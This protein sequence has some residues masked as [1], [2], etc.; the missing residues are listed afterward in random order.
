[1]KTPVPR[2]SSRRPD[3]ARSAVTAF[4]PHLAVDCGVWHDTES[5]AQ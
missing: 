2:R 5:F 4:Q 1:M 3:G